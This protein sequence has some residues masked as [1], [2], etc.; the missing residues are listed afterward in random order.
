MKREG[1]NWDS[2]I[3]LKYYHDS[4][5]RGPQKSLHGFFSRRVHIQTAYVSRFLAV[6]FLR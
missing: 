2:F 6:N 3:Q 4:K 1:V 5:Y